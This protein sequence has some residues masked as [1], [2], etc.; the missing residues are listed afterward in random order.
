MTESTI[1]APE[2]FVGRE[3]ELRQLRYALSS[4]ASNKRPQFVLIQGDVGAGKTALV[5]S[6]LASVPA[7]ARNTLIGQG[8]CALETERNGLV[9]FSQ[10]LGRLA[11]RGAQMRLIAGSVWEFV[12][13]VAPAWLNLV[14]I[15]LAEPVFTTVEAGV[16][17][18]TQSKF[19]EEN[20]FA[21]FT[22]AIA[23]LAERRP[24]IVFIDDLH[25]AD[26][27]SL[28][29]LFHLQRNLTSGAMLFLCTYRPLIT[30]G[31][32]ANTQIFNEIR[33]N[34]IRSGASEIELRAEIDV[35][36]YVAQRYP[37]NAF[38]ADFIE[39]IQKATEGH[40]LFID[41]LFDLWE[42]TGVLCSS[43]GPDH[44]PFWSVACGENVQIDIPPALTEVLGQRIRILENGL[45]DILTYAAVEGEDFAAQV[46]AKVRQLDELKVFDDLEA[47]EHD[48][49]L[50]QEE[51]LRPVRV[52]DLD[53]YRFGQRFIRE[54]VYNQLPAGKRRIIHRQV[55]ECLESLYADGDVREVASQLAWHFG[56]AR[57]PWKAARYALLAAEREQERYAWIE[58]V[59]L[60]DEGLKWLDPASRD[61]QV[62]GLR[63]DLIEKSAL[64][65]LSSGRFADGHQRYSTAL[66]VAMES[67]ASAE[68]TA[69]LCAQFADLVE[70]EGKYD[71]VVRI[72]DQGMQ[73]LAR[74]NTPFGEAGVQLRWL[75]G[76]MLGRY[77]DGVAAVDALRTLLTDAEDLAR[78]VT[79]AHL[80]VRIH[81]SLG[82]VLYELGYLHESLTSFQQGLALADDSGYDLYCATLSLNMVSNY[83][84]LHDVDQSL[85]HINKGRSQAQRVGD[86]DSL[87]YA[88][89]QEAEVALILSKPRDAITKLVAAKGDAESTGSLW[90][91]GHMN[92]VL[93]LAHMILAELDTAAKMAERGVAEA[94]EK[95]YRF[96]LGLAFDALGQVEAAQ[97]K[98]EAAA[99]HLGQAIEIH[100]LAGHRVNLALAE[101][102]LAQVWQRQGREQEARSL[103]TSSL[104]AFQELEVAYEVTVTERLLRELAVKKSDL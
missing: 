60:C 42:S 61:P 95:N 43:P 13:E 97:Q 66:A 98:L 83:I 102:H 19:P 74:S 53:Y 89:A 28:R 27:S 22:N 24:I 103:L 68:R 49:H 52:K 58:S 23:Q 87:M 46:V 59:K 48:Y 67:K 41:Q 70:F 45:R 85:A 1:N 91:V 77:G 29:L 44:R 36:S 92:T 31:T 39:R 18:A 32:G 96:E 80:F 25:W 34:L 78:T 69:G 40:P 6:F 63:L 3:G 84:I 16:K 86:R 33:A 20:V 104:A 4:T 99:N 100:R 101:Q 35:R 30:S 93:A 47:L 14:T 26:E 90:Y 21:Q 38:D 57:E 10:V 75:Q 64:S 55:G 11:E 56:E 37:Q 82:V 15:G 79:L 17:M 81:N 73:I 76:L 72:V 50:I 88:Q 62:M 54:Y 5:E 94:K 65:C 51:E 7:Q 12:K 9:P 8:K 2:F 71:D